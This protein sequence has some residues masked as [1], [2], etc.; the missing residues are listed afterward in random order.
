MDV[1]TKSVREVLKAEAGCR[2]GV[3]PD[4]VALVMAIGWGAE[5]R[6]PF[7]W[8]AVRHCQTYHRVSR[9]CQLHGTRRLRVVGVEVFMRVH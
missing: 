5:L 3:V 9:G 1:A 6:I 7:Q 2:V 8:D 4:S